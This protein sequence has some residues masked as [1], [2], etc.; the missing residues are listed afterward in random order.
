MNLS[1]SICTQ[2]EKPLSFVSVPLLALTLDMVLQKIRAF[3]TWM[4]ISQPENQNI[5]S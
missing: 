5:Q 1:V 2:I 3:R 4:H